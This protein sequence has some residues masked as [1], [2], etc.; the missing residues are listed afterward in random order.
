MD[1]KKLDAIFHTLIDDIKGSYGHWQFT[2]GDTQIIC[3]TDELHN[4]MRFMAPIIETSKM[5]DT[6]MTASLE[7]NFH[8][9]LDIKYAIS[10]DV[11]WAVFMHPLRELTEGQVEDAIQQVYAGAQNFGTS[12][13]S[14]NLYFP[15][16]E[17]RKNRMN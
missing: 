17:D 7:A 14:S 2:L 8:T 9:A 1:N 4:R 13:S 3:L 12:Y 11:L 6:Q 16:K 5:T 10:D 15:T